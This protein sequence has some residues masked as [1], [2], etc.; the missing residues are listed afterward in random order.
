M[1]G[2]LTQVDL[3]VTR[4]LLIVL[5]VYHGYELCIGGDLIVEHEV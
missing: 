4:T 3:R 2:A 5:T 1:N